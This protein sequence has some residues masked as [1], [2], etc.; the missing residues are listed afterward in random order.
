MSVSIPEA[1]IEQMLVKEEAKAGTR[2]C[3]PVKEYDAWAVKEE[4]NVPPTQD[5]KQAALMVASSRLSAARQ[6][7][8]LLPLPPGPPP[9]AAGAVGAV[10]GY[11]AHPAYSAPWVLSNEEVKK[12]NMHYATVPRPVLES[13]WTK[14]QA[15]TIDLQ[16][17]IMMLENALA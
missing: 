2:N 12:H 5:E 9:K 4:L 8:G 6:A 16:S 14:A 10:G 7:A 1:V 17:R 3:Q 11:V 13:G 15:P